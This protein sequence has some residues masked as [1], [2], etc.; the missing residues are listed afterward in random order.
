MPNN[1]QNDSGQGRSR[2]AGNFAN[3][4]ERARRAGRKGGQS[5]ARN[6]SK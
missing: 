1:N 5:R 2:N 4:P 6:S 3:D